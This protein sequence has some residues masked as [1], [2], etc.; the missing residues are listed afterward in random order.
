M[1]ILR[2]YKVLYDTDQYNFREMLQDHLGFHNLSLIHGTVEQIERAHRV[3]PGDDQHT[4]VH[5][6]LYEIDLDFMRTYRSFVK[7]VAAPIVLSSSYLYQSIPTF[8]IHMPGNKAVGGEWHKDTDYNHPKGEI[9]FLVPLTRSYGSNTIHIES[10]PGLG[11]FNPVNMEYGEMLV[12]DG[13]S[14]R[15][16]NVLN[17]TGLTR[18]SFDFRI[19][20]NDKVPAQS[21][22]RSVCAGIEFAEG[23]YYS[24][25]EDLAR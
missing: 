11:D 8:R 19:L 20:P 2:N 12:F 3:S 14:C 4:S 17:T 25:C 15:H 16:G 5:R 9:N 10:S 18:V 7:N 24:R 23:G 21:P 13:G 22:G 1:A 6:R